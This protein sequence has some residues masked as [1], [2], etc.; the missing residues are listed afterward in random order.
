VPQACGAAQRCTPTRIAAEEKRTEW[1]VRQDG[2]RAEHEAGGGEADRPRR[3]PRRQRH[4]GAEHE[5]AALVPVRLAQ[6]QHARVLPHHRDV[7]RVRGQAR[8]RAGLVRHGDEHLVPAGRRRAAARAVC[9][10]RAALKPWPKWGHAATAGLDPAA[11]AAMLR[12]RASPA[13]RR[14][15]PR[16]HADRSS[17]PARR[18]V[19]GSAAARAAAPARH[20]GHVGVELQ[21]VGLAAVQLCAHVARV[22][23]P[24]AVHQRDARQ[25]HLLAAERARVGM[26]ASCAGCAC[27]RL[28]RIATQAHARAGTPRRRAGDARQQRP[29]SCRAG[30]GALPRQCR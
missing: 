4:R 10:A 19:C 25:P 23:G 20:H 7:R 11:H 28:R 17:A 1:H 22:A 18:L 24:L 13:G 27:S 2:G 15:A 8:A 5:Q 12:M 29:T 16:A 9:L 21:V 26:P 14:M 6:R 30:R 3:R